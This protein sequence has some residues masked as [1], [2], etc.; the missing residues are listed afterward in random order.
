MMAYVR[1]TRDRWDIETN[2]GYGWDVECSEYTYKEAKER[3]KEY[4]ENICGAGIRM[5]KRREPISLY[6]AGHEGIKASRIREDEPD[7]V[8]GAPNYDKFEG[9]SPEEV[10]VWLN[11]D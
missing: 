8:N 7:F 1:K 9:W 3:L 4:R 11:V 10:L 6:P 5:R 2:Y